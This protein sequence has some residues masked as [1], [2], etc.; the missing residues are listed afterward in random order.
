M[1]NRVQQQFRTSSSFQ[2]MEAPSLKLHSPCSQLLSKNTRCKYVR[3]EN[4]QCR[5][6]SDTN[7]GILMTTL[8]EGRASDYAPVLEISPLS[9]CFTGGSQ[10]DG[11]VGL[12]G[13]DFTP[14]GASVPSSLCKLAQ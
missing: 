10:G 11:E 12:L 3:V 8:G 7:V 6:Q 4:V 1:L 14:S 9:C 5:Q 13:V 2:E